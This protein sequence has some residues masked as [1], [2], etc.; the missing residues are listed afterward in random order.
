[1]EGGVK[2]FALDIA[3]LLCAL[4]LVAALIVRDVYGKLP[5]YG[6]SNTQA[7]LE[8]GVVM[9]AVDTALPSLAGL[10]LFGTIAG[11]FRAWFW[12]S[13]ETKTL[14]K[15]KPKRAGIGVRVAKPEPKPSAPIAL[16]DGSDSNPD[17][18]RVTVETLRR[19][20]KVAKAAHMLNI[21][22]AAVNKRVHKMYERDPEYV[23]DAI[24]DWVERNIKG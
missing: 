18:L 14:P 6:F 4:L 7:S 10:L 13:N 24:P 9:L 17:D 20:G 19:V 15:P 21:S 23:G 5:Q 2:R 22:P 11:A 12:H 16:T 3:L 8:W 1:M